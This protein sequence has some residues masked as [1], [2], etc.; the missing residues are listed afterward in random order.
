M[1]QV[2]VIGG[3]ST[4]GRLLQ[5]LLSVDDGLR[6]EHFSMP[7]GGGED[8]HWP[9]KVELVGRRYE[10]VLVTVRSW[11]PMI[12]SK[13]ERHVPLGATVAE[14]E[15]MFAY[16]QIMAWLTGSGNHWRFVVYEALIADPDR[17]MAD[18]W[19][20]LGRPRLAVSEDI[21]DGNAK[22]YEEES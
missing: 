14:L 17:V 22:W 2:L 13:V 6:V 12:R 8:R 11:S 1:V 9:T 10:A 20:W 3:E 16:E 21:V 4:G 19:D 7:H 18:I 5:R 15:A